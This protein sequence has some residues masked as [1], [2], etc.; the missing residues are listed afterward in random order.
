[1]TCPNCNN[2]IPDGLKFCSECGTNLINVNS[3]N[4]NI[5]PQNNPEHYPQNYTQGPT[6]EQYATTSLR[7]GI[8]GTCMDITVFLSIVGLILGIVGIKKASNA[9]RMGVKTGKQK[10]GLILSIISLVLS[11]VIPFVFLAACVDRAKKNSDAA[12]IV[13]NAENGN[14]ATALQGT[15]VGSNGSVLVLR[16]DMTSNYYYPGFGISTNTWTLE[17]NKLEMF[18]TNSLCNVEADIDPNKTDSFYLTSTSP[19]WDAETFTKVSADTEKPTEQQCDELIRQYAPNT[20]LADKTSTTA[21]TKSTEANTQSTTA[22]NSSQ[23]ATVNDMSVKEALDEYEAYVDKYVDLYKGMLD[24]SKNYFEALNEINELQGEIDDLE[25]AMNS[26]SESDMTPEEYQ[27]YIEVMSRI[28]EK[29]LS[30]YE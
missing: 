16:D 18:V 24:G 7:F 10:A 9:S 5:P 15:Y 30:I 29:M 19:L 1:M 23:G 11:V 28:S 17:D 2:N 25:K 4:Y 3:Q 27:Y 8:V 20:S 26:L 22:G 6:G 21:T 13:S 14:L 12:A